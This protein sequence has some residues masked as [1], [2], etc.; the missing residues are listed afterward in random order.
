MHVMGLSLLPSLSSG[1]LAP[2]PSWS[3]ADGVSSLGLTTH[4][5]GK[6]EHL[7]REGDSGSADRVRAGL[8][9]SRAN[10]KFG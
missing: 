10:R 3:Q 9:G 2:G 4:L 6:T 7:L 5:E 1:E 8:S